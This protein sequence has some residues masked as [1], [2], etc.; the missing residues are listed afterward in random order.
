MG[1]GVFRWVVREGFFEV[2]IFMSRFDIREG[3]RLWRFGKILF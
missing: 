3:V 1:G 2:F